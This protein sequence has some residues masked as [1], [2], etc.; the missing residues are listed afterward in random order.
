MHLPPS[1]LKS[2]S[3][4]LQ[5]QSS[6]REELQHTFIPSLSHPPTATNLR[7]RS[8]TQLFGPLSSVSLIKEQSRIEAMLSQP[9]IFAHLCSAMMRFERSW[10]RFREQDM[11]RE[12]SGNQL[13]ILM[14]ECGILFVPCNC[15]RQSET[16]LFRTDTQSRSY[17]IRDKKKPEK[18][19]T[20]KR[21]T[22]PGKTHVRTRSV[23]V[24]VPRIIWDGSV[25]A[26][27]DLARTWLDTLLS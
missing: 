20:L 16:T 11:E 4:S 13:G 23:N 21:H 19:C 14:E 10:F 22:K 12:C 25:R 8:N 17:T 24:T 1:D 9:R 15:H 18:M 26:K 5:H 3:P 6:D 27:E 7:S 2:L